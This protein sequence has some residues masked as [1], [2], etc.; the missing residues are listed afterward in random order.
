MKAENNQNEINEYKIKEKIRVYDTVIK[1][2]VKF[3]NNSSNGNAEGI[4]F[5]HETDSAIVVSHAFPL[6]KNHTQEDISNIVSFKS[7]IVK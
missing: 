1:S 5:G 6:N 2:L 7:F 3:S 4:L